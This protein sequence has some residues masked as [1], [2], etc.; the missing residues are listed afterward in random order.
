METAFAEL[1][2]AVFTTLAPLGAGAFVVLAAAFF[3][4]SFTDAQVKKIDRMT[5]IP[6]VAILVGF[7]ASFAHLAS[8]MAATGVFSGMGNSP[9]SNEI[10]V[11]SLFVVVALVYVIWALTGKMGAGAR[12][13]LVAVVAVL[14]VVFAVFTGMAYMMDTIVSWN[15][16]LVPVQMLGFALVG[17]AA[18]A[19]FV[20]ALA[21]SLGDACKGSFKMAAMAIS[22][23]G[24][25][26]AVGGLCIQVMGVGGMSNALV[27]GA[28]LVAEVTMWLV[29]AVV[30]LIA[31]AAATIAACMGKSPA[32]LAGAATV[33]AVVG[34]FLARLVFYAVQLSVG[35]SL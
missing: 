29:G 30:C 1:P 10:A 4:T 12:K 16:P 34:I 32:A 6:L 35:L 14:A 8:P 24:V 3:T 11:G 20:L 23:V 22:V 26:L 13:G 7:A 27:S 5:L 28:D 18:T 33:L 19:T 21:G 9:L 25:V 31:A 17:G 2:L 15:T